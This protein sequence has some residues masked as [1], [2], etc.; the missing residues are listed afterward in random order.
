MKSYQSRVNDWMHACFPP[1][2]REDIRERGDR[3]LEETLE[4]L[5]AH[6]YDPERVAT[7]TRYV[8]GRP[9]GEPEQEL[10][11]V[12]VTLAAFSE[13]AGLHMDDCAELELERITQPEIMAKI[14]KKQESKRGLHTPLPVPPE[15]V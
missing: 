4:L 8:Y 6:G 11:G 2:V 9:V 1:E 7:L 13:T 15:A 14:Q 12:M 3:L 5:Q 10:G